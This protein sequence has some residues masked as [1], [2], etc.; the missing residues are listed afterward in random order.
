[1]PP[2]TASYQVPRSFAL[3]LGA[4]AL[5]A[6]LSRSWR[7]RPR[8][9]P[10]LPQTNANP[11]Y[12]STAA[13]QGV[14]DSTT[15]EPPA[16]PAIM[17]VGM[18]T[19]PVP[20]DALKALLIDLDGTMC[21]SDPLHFDALRELLVEH[22]YNSGVPIDMPFFHEHI[23]GRD[24]RDIM[25]FLFPGAEPRWCA[26]FLEEKERRLRALVPTALQ[27]VMGLTKFLA[28]VRAQ[29]LRTAVVT[30]APRDNAELMLET[31]GFKDYFDALVIG[32]ECAH[33]KP[34]PDPYRTA[35]QQLGVDPSNALALEDSPSGVASAAAAGVK[36]VGVTTAYSSAELRASGAELTVPHY[37]GLYCYCP[38]AL[39]PYPPGDRP[40][41]WFTAED[42]LSN[43]CPGHPV[44]IAGKVWPTSEHYYQ[45]RKF[46][47]HL[48]LQ[49]QIRQQPTCKQAAAIGR[50]PDNQHKFAPSWDEDKNSVMITA[51]LAKFTQNEACRSQLL[52]THGKVLMEYSEK[53]K[54]WGDAGDFRGSNYLGKALMILRDHLMA[55]GPEYV[56]DGD[57]GEAEIAAL[58]ARTWPQ[59]RGAE[60]QG[61]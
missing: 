3:L 12:W 46:A 35:L 33:G 32:P 57:G 54:Y 56:W 21:L 14:A 25:R 8:R 60:A 34:H 59:A 18:Q 15:H 51:L 11:T 47:G 4:L 38:G 61:R 6:A 39:P 55:R 13:I 40:T 20:S 24:S 10:L 26:D 58:V 31:L 29:G 41:I 50:H 23:S 48:E 52:N 19:L 27:P 37:V 1:V 22:G 36:V 16:E 30:N 17:S 49:E 45:S 5:L 42:V 44:R 2:A 9:G 53:D 43:F 7:H 28:W